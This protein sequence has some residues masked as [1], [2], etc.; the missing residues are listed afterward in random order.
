MHKD[1]PLDEVR[2]EIGDTYGRLIAWENAR[3][4][5]ARRVEILDRKPS[6]TKG[7][8]RAVE[9]KIDNYLE[10]VID[11]RNKHERRLAELNSEYLRQLIACGNLR[12]DL[13][14][15]MGEKSLV[16]EKELGDAGLRNALKTF[17]KDAKK[18]L[19]HG[20]SNELYS[21]IYLKAAD[22]VED[23]LPKGRKKIRDFLKDE[24][25]SM[26][27]AL[28]VIGFM[29]SV[30]SFLDWIYKN[31]NVVRLRQWSKPKMSYKI[32]DNLKLKIDRYAKKLAIT[33]MSKRDDLDTFGFV[34]GDIEGE[35]GKREKKI[36][37]KGFLPLSKLLDYVL[38]KMEDQVPKGFRVGRT[39]FDYS[40]AIK[41]GVA[42]EEAEFDNLCHE[43]VNFL[44]G[45]RKGEQEECKALLQE[46]LD[47]FFSIIKQHRPGFREA[48]RGYLMC[49]NEY[50]QMLSRWRGK[51]IEPYLRTHLLGFFY[52]RDSLLKL[53]FPKTMGRFADSFL[54]QMQ[55]VCGFAPKV[56]PRLIFVEKYDYL[57]LHD[58]CSVS[59]SDDGASPGLVITYNE[60]ARCN[61]VGW[62]KHNMDIERIRFMDDRDE[63]MA[64]WVKF[65]L[66]ET[67]S[68]VVP[69]LPKDKKLECK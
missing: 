26:N 30:F 27:A 31:Q 39:R 64:I 51:D 58:F 20:K 45:R 7:R 36:V 11:E 40:D 35:G 48:G 59:K 55:H 67:S 9:G 38:E 25:G 46:I 24:K 44:E 12:D 17:G 8:S 23:E 65:L 15:L 4:E 28:G 1:R 5:A 21:D 63:E 29:L 14:K 42:K 13:S 10:E 60:E 61:C 50:R 68:I 19:A 6:R 47:K 18:F 33:S 52:Y 16:Q 54:K 43:F 32:D 22:V 41:L 66:D 34:F 57:M 3:R 56:M 2:R 69:A 62:N 49:S 53:D 37:V